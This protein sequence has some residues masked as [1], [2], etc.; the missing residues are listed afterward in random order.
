M[1]VTKSDVKSD[2]GNEEFNFG[3]EDDYGDAGGGGTTTKPQQQQ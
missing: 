3:L 1:A 2:D